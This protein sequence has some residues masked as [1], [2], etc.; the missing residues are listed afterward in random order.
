MRKHVAALL[1]GTLASASTS[2]AAFV[3]MNVV[4]SQVTAGSDT[5]YVFKV[6][7]KF[8]NANDTV[9]N[10]YGMNTLPAGS[11]NHNDFLSGGMNSNGAGTW[12]PALV[13]TA[14]VGLAGR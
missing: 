1:A 3:G 9:L 11:F 8:N 13:P 7:A 5:F 10:L 2:D 12:S 14:T 4:S 6:Y